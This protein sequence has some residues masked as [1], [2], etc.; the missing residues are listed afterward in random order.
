M[1]RARRQA[2]IAS[3]SLPLERYVVACLTYVLYV[4]DR[5]RALFRSCYSGED[6]P[7]H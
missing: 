7:M 4:A 1:S 6:P 2:V 5:D 3:A